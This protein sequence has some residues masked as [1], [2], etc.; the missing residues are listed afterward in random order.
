MGVVRFGL[1][2]LVDERGREQRV[3]FEAQPAAI[4]RAPVSPPLIADF[5]EIGVDGRRDAGGGAHAEGAAF[6]VPNEN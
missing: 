2:D 3:E 5:F 6:H 1:G 4:A